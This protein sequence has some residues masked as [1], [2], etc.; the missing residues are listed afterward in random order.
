[1]DTHDTILGLEDAD[2]SEYMH[3]DVYTATEEAYINV[4]SRI[5][6]YLAIPKP[7]TS[8]KNEGET[9]SAIKQL[10][11]SKIELPKFSLEMC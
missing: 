7:A 10:Q 5:T 4:K 3:M 9:P 8:I 11:L 2:E 6:A 1:M